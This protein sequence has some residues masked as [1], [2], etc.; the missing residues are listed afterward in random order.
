MKVLSIFCASIDILERRIYADEISSRKLTIVWKIDNDIL[1]ISI[2]L[3]IDR[4]ARII[5]N[6]LF[7]YNQI[8]SNLLGRYTVVFDIEMNYSSDNDY[9][10]DFDWSMI[11]FNKWFNVFVMA[12]EKMLYFVSV[13]SFVFDEH[14]TDSIRVYDKNYVLELWQ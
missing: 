13:L 2:S 3:Y 12:Y 10:E 4:S 5:A 6:K 8:H 1:K 9:I 7:D 14:H 11:L